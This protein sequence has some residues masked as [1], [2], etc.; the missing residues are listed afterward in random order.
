MIVVSDAVVVMGASVP[1]TN[2][3]KAAG[4]MLSSKTSGGMVL[5]A[6]LVSAKVN[7][8]SATSSILM[9]EAL[10]AVVITEASVSSAVVTNSIETAGVMPL[11]YA[12][13]TSGGMALDAV[14]VS[15]TLATS[16]G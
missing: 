3:V 16:S 10:N 8:A 11:S 4:V 7:E 12:G 9:I 13:E 1:S 6:V 2:S 14:L 5:A 15:G